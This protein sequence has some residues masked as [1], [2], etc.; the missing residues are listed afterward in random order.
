[1][2]QHRSD[3]VEWNTLKEIA[4]ADEEMECS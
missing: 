4:A 2:R 3:L 1:M